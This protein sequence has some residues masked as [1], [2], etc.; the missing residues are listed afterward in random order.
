M[1][2]VTPRANNN[3]PLRLSQFDWKKNHRLATQKYHTKISARGR[4]VESLSSGSRYDTVP[5][6]KNVASNHT[7]KVT[8]MK[9]PRSTLPRGKRTQ[10]LLRTCGG[11]FGFEEI[12]A[13]AETIIRYTSGISRKT[14]CSPQTRMLPHMLM[15]RVPKNI[16]KN[17][18]KLQPQVATNVVSSARHDCAIRTQRV[19]LKI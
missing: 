12:G 18:I 5:P 11:H 13:I 19:K 4:M 14:R 1:L 17:L 16:E 7:T 15:V 8:T 6:L 10:G 2:I 9:V 3:E